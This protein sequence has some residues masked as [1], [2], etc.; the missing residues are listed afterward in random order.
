M[1]PLLLFWV[2]AALRMLFVLFGAGGIWFFWGII[3]GF[4]AALLGM[5]GLVVLQLSYLYQLGNWLDNPN[6]EKLPDGW[7]AWTDKIGRA[8]CRERV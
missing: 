3:P 6:S 1:N 8:S 7:G 2:P 5:G 4:L